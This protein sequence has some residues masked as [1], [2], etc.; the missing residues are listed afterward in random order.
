MLSGIA[1]VTE[2]SGKSRRVHW[3]MACSKLL[4]QSFHEFAA[5]SIPWCDWAKA[6]YLTLRERGKKHNAAVRALA[7]KWL[8]IMFRRWKSK[9]AYDDAVY[10]TSLKQ[11]SPDLFERAFAVR[12]E[13]QKKAQA[14]AAA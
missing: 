11:R 1:P 6:Y 12:E 13:R 2:A 5:Q 9:T 3:R 4:R 14:R 8:R 7:F 10:M